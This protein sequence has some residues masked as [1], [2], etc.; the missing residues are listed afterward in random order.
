MP[1]T[2]IVTGSSGLIGSEVVA[3]LDER[4]WRVEGVDNNMRADFFG[5]EGD[6]TWNLERL[7]RET[8][9]FTHNDLDIRDRDAMLRLLDFHGG[10]RIAWLRGIDTGAILEGSGLFGAP[11]YAEFRHE[12]RFDVDGLVERVSSISYVAL[13]EPWHR[14]RYLVLPGMTG[15]WQIAGRSNLSFDELVRFDFFYVDTWSIWLD[16]SI[17][18]KTLPAVLAGRGAY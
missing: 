15:L 4:G 7:L 18:A 14:K 6:T 2:A 17:L 13:L 12:Q 1:K 5:P 16:I 10:T 3:F 8:T 9:R 11:E